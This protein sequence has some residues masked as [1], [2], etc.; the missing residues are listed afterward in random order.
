VEA[1]SSALLTR[2]LPERRI[3]LALV[4]LVSASIS[5]EQEATILFQDR[6]RPV[7]GIKSRWARRR[8]RRKAPAFLHEPLLAQ[9]IAS[10]TSYKALRGLNCHGEKTH[11]QPGGTAFHRMRTRGRALFGQVAITC[12]WR[13]RT[14]SAGEDIKGLSTTKFWATRR[15]FS[16]PWFPRTSAPWPTCQFPSP[17]SSRMGR[18]R[19]VTAWSPTRRA[20]SSSLDPRELR[21][22]RD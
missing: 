15:R 11:C 22:L 16:P 4:P 1:D 2:E 3:D 10:S 17:R 5:E 8:R 19:R 21:S 14:T 18:D 13:L 20:E 7:V 6:L 12:R 9:D